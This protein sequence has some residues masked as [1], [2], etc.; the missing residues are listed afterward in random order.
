MNMIYVV[1]KILDLNVTEGVRNDAIDAA[2]TKGKINTDDLILRDLGY[3]NL[4]V[5]TGF[6]NAGAFF[7]SRSECLY[8]N[9][10]FGTNR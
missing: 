10:R 5:L 1:V 3:Y 4:S 6:A 9:L 2:E 7:I 8:P